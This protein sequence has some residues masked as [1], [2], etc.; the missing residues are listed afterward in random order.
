MASDISPPP[1]DDEAVAIAAAVEALWP[2]P[3]L[4]QPAD[5]PLRTPTWRFSNRWWAM[6][7]PSRR[8]RPFL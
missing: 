7:L 5:S 1:T 2:R 3:L 6:P 4:A 8:G